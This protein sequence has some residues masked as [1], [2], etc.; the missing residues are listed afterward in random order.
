[1]KKKYIQPNI[2]TITLAEELAAGPRFSA[3]NPGDGNNQG[4][5][6]GN[7]GDEADAKYHYFDNIWED[8]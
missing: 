5:E 4:L 2:N 1:M 8:E 6:E 7:N 3:V